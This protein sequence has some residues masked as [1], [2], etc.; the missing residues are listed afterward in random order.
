M[1]E[2]IKYKSIVAIRRGGPEV[3]Q[4]VENDLKPPAVGQVQVKV[5]ATGVG[6]TD[7]NYL[8]GR[9][10]FA[11]RPPFT[12]GYEVMGI[13]DAVGEGVT[14]AKVGDRV[15]AL[16]GHGSYTEI[17]YLGQEHLVQVPA[18]V[19]PAD[20]VV[21]TLNYV[22]AYQMLYRVAKVKTGDKALL[23]G[24]SGGV[25]TA[26][27]E[28]GKLAGL[29][30]VGLASP[31]KH[32]MLTGMGVTPVD[33]HVSNLKDALSKVEPDGFDVVFDG[34]GGPSGDLGLSALK[35]GGKLVGYS[36]PKSMREILAGLANML[37]TNLFSGK[38]ATF[39]GITV[40]YHQD[41]KPFMEDIAILF[42]ML[43][44]G[45]IKP[46]I[47]ARLPL[48]E[49]RKANEMLESGQVQGNIVLLVPE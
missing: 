4:I 46:V 2:T 1:K 22:T 23:I 16:T 25:G 35:P 15:A 3:L 7:L 48:L 20:A 21:I 47:T 9:S 32:A 44:E 28:I 6:G 13:V 42:D 14:R 34:I 38:S 19:S 49:A 36:A 5:L 31:P 11:P 26:L 33:Y 10:P 39:Y 40:L 27:M 12:P 37:F 17:M 8:H 29:K 24:A 43:A 30:M 45:K 18:S 41:K